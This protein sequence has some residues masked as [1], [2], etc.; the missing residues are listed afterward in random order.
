M[1]GL[2]IP[3]LIANLISL[4]IALP[5]HEFA[6]AFTANAFGDDTPRANGRLTLNPLAHL[7]IF[8]SMMMILVGF[9]WAKPVPVNPSA[10]NRRSPSALMWVS[11]AGPMSNF[12]MAL[13]AAI[14]LRLNLIP[15]N[16]SGEILPSAYI[17]LVSFIWTNL[18]LALF[19]LIPVSPLDGDKI[20]D[21]FAP[22]PMA[23]VLDV[24]R[25]YG[26]FILLAVVLIL[27]RL[28]FDVFGWIITPAISV[29]WQLIVGG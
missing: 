10:L 20:A 11:L 25:P 28:G 5:M 23:R 3:S 7:D 24:I 22:P 21:Y 19:N 2:S 9:G 18:V 27:P 6:H 29:L 16:P 1:L 4:F 17:L 8:G 14:P 12:V 13:L 26:P 15:Y